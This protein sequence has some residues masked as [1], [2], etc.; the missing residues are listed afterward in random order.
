LSFIPPFVVA[1][2]ELNGEEGEKREKS[3]V[4]AELSRLFREQWRSTP[5]HPRSPVFLRSL[6][7][8]EFPHLFAKPLQQDAQEFLCVLLDHLHETSNHVKRRPTI[9]NLDSSSSDDDD[10]DG[11][12]EEE[13]EEEED[14]SEISTRAWNNYQRGNDSY[15]KD[16]FC[17][18]F[19]SRKK[20]TACEKKSFTCDIFFDVQ[21]P[22][23][24]PSVTGNKSLKLEELL[25][26]YFKSERLV[27]LTCTRC[28]QKGCITKQLSIERFPCVLVIM[29]KRS[30]FPSNKKVNTVVSFPLKG[31]RI[32]SSASQQT[33]VYDLVS[34][35][36]HTGLYSTSGHYTSDVLHPLTRAWFQANDSGFTPLP[37]NQRSAVGKDAFML[38]YVDSDKLKNSADFLLTVE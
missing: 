26:D 3:A 9:D 12:E 33:R 25:R 23:A 7:A 16:L 11:D 4:I 2:L 22:I 15:I 14:T 10:G 1:I 38:F 18:Q 20:C 35:V 13:E 37:G 6:F 32:Q 29:F 30:I 19:M 5:V 28:K 27:E 36:N 17:G 24:L 31:L 8:D 34:V 21:L